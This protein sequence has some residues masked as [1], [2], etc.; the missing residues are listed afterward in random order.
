MFDTIFSVVTNLI[1]AAF[2]TLLWLGA[3]ILITSVFGGCAWQGKTA[4]GIK[5]S[6]PAGHCGEAKDPHACSEDLTEMVDIATATWQDMFGVQFYLADLNQLDTIDLGQGA[7][8]CPTQKNPAR[9][10]SGIFWSDGGA[11]K[12]ALTRNPC[13]AFSS[14]MH[15]LAHFFLKLEGHADPDHNLKEVFYAPGSFEARAVGAGIAAGI[16]PS[17]RVVK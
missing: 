14:L 6:A 8:S 13:L 16:C 5:W 10:C 4:Q 7:L 11:W 2:I 15:E 1:Y 3:L 12:I 9:K 17:V